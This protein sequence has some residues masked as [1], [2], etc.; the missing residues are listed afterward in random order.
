MP[1]ARNMISNARRRKKEKEEHS[2]V[3]HEIVKQI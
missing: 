3:Q 1:G 2:V